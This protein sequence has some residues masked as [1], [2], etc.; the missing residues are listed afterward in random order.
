MTKKLIPFRFSG[1]PNL[2]LNIPMPKVKPPRLISREEEAMVHILFALEEL[3]KWPD[4]TEMPFGVYLDT[5]HEVAPKPLM[6]P[7]SRMTGIFEA[8]HRHVEEIAPSARK[9]IDAYYREDS[10]EREIKELKEAGE[11]YEDKLLKG[12]QHS[13]LCNGNP[14]S[15][16]GKKDDI[17]CC[18]P[19]KEIKH[20]RHELEVARILLK[21]ATSKN[22]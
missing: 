12:T 10:L 17:C 6:V 19:G 7:P 13:L 4:L 21:E 14:N 8:L 18:P 5:E 3:S 20:L 9:A 11:K 22:G 2:D 1:L 15:K 16:V